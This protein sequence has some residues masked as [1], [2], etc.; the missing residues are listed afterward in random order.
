[1]YI[2]IYIYDSSACLSV[3]HSFTFLF[4]FNFKIIIIIIILFNISKPKTNKSKLT[5]IYCKYKIIKIRNIYQIKKI[6]RYLGKI[7]LIINR[8]RE[9]ERKRLLKIL[10]FLTYHQSVFHFKFIN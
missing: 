9:R 6:I 1:M 3:C 5:K 2:Y 4:C 7:S 8:E 10:L